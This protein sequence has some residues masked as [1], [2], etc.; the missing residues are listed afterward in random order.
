MMDTC[1]GRTDV[2]SVHVGADDNLLVVPHILPL[3]VPREALT[4]TVAEWLGITHT[5]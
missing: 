3:R 2:A 5:P 1:S 4:L